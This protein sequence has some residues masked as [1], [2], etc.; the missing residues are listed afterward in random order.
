MADN[1]DRK[2][3]QD[4]SRINIHEPYELKWWSEELKISKEELIAVVERVGTSAESVKEE[5]KG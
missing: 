1:L 4:S 2:N 3:P 5:L